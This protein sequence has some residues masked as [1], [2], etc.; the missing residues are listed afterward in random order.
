[1]SQACKFCGCT[2]DRAC[3]IPIVVRDS[4]TCKLAGDMTPA[5]GSMPCSWLLSDVCDAPRCVEKA[6]REAR[7]LVCQLYG[8]Q[9]FFEIVDPIPELSL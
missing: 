4:E 3:Q 2:E 7:T 1:M 9:G 6:Y 5:D 8:I